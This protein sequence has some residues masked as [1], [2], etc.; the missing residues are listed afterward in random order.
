M[1]E[2]SPIYSAKTGQQIGHVEGNQAFDLFGRP[3]AMYNMDTGLLYDLNSETPVGYV[4]LTNIFVG[5]S[6]IAEKLFPKTEADLPPRGPLQIDDQAS[7]APTRRIEHADREDINVSP[8]IA[9][10]PRGQQTEETG[11]AVTLSVVSDPVSPKG[12]SVQELAS[13][14]VSFTPVTGPSQQNDGFGAAQLALTSPDRGSFS[15]DQHSRPQGASGA[16]NFSAPADPG[17]DHSDDITAAPTAQPDD[18]CLPIRAP[19]EYGSAVESARPDSSGVGSVPPAVEAFMRSLA[20][21]VSLSTSQTATLA[22]STEGAVGP[23]LSASSAAQKDVDQVSLQDERYTGEPDLLAAGD[24]LALPAA[25][26]EAAKDQRVVED[27]PVDEG[28]TAAE[29]ELA[30][31]D[32]PVA[33]G[34]PA[35]EEQTA[36][37]EASSDSITA[38]P[39]PITFVDPRGFE[40]VLRDWRSDDAGDVGRESLAQSDFTPQAGSHI[41]ETP[42]SAFSERDRAA[43]PNVCEPYDRT[44][45]DDAQ[46]R[47]Y[48]DDPP[49]AADDAPPSNGSQDEASGPD[50]ALDLAKVFFEV[51]T[52]RAVAVARSELGSRNTVRAGADRDP[53]EDF[54]SVDIE[55]AV[56]LVR[57][58]LAEAVHTTDLP[59][60]VGEAD[61]TDPTRETFSTEMD[62]VLKAVLRELEKKPR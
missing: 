29:D 21:Y 50:L 23:E 18:A 54:F 39:P 58:E 43:Q 59:G 55:R 48:F 13:Q 45:Q 42:G 14:A 36:A 31:K 12:A 41:D 2:H 16:D 27:K 57:D 33:K 17:S 53:T 11:P 44:D 1:A 3:C 38:T 62:R 32:E 7:D 46:G 6:W 51:D 24:D 35:A 10:T 30:A 22:A 5:S 4:S 61:T 15:S 28:E 25:E 56:R 26:E 8:P 20:A 34:D 9:Q 49:A 47:E 52:E 40:S 37:D 60:A 19:S